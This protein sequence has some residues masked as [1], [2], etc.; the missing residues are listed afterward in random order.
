MTASGGGVAGLQVR[1]IRVLLGT[2][3]TL[4]FHINGTFTLQAGG[5]PVQQ[6]RRDGWTT[7]DAQAPL[8][9]G[10][11]RVPGGRA[12]IVPQK[13]ATFELSYQR[14]GRWTPPTRYAGKLVLLAQPSE[15]AMLINEVN[16]ETYVAG[17][18]TRELYPD[19]HREAY[20]AQAVA[21]RTYAMFQM[22]K[23]AGREY[24]VTSGESSQV[25]GG[26]A[27]GRAAPKAIEAVHY[28][29]GI[30]ATWRSPSGERIF[31]TYYSSACGGMSQDIAYV[32]PE[33]TVPPLSGGVVCNY[34]RNAK[35]EA[36]RWKPV[37]LAKT[38]VESRLFSRYPQL[39]ETLGRLKTVGVSARTRTGRP[40]KIRLVGTTGRQHGLVAEDF[41]LA[42]GSRT[43]RSTDC[44]IEDHGSSLVLSN[45]RGFGH[46]V[47]LCQWG[48]QGQALAGRNAAQILKH[49]YP[50]MHLT[51]AY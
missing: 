46:G 24:D 32:K 12:E 36:Y 19:F 37:R 22:A 2:E 38:E 49:Y 21:A 14:E 34:C 47:G 41:R 31:C 3:S 43:M 42:V 28:T 13:G 6:P 29:H 5:P 35:G 11:L 48:A 9:I 44:T 39:A 50:G 4:R 8:T 45:G 18:L 10:A 27:E 16:L 15:R 7:V 25:Y 23:N 33:P 1:D 40:A 17:V 51:R 26:L 30:V 20:R